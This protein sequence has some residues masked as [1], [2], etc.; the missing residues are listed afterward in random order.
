[1]VG[2][3]HIYVYDNASTDASWEILADYHNS[4]SVTAIPWDAPHQMAYITDHIK[5]QRLAYWHALSNYG[6][7]WRWMTFI[8]SDEFLMPAQGDNLHDLL[9]QYSDLPGLALFWKIFGTAG[10]LNPPSGLVIENYTQRA[11]FPELTHTKTIVDPRSVSV[12]NGVHLIGDQLYDEQR[13]PI[14]VADINENQRRK[15]SMLTQEYAPSSD[16][17]NLHHYYTRSQAEFSAKIQ[18]AEGKKA[19]FAES[20]KTIGRTLEANLASDLS[21]TRFV[22]QLKKRLEA[23]RPKH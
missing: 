18:R 1:M 11:P 2:V 13:R 23:A 16:V 3:E 20:M 19:K 14:R 9:Q 10:H 8:D 7:K 15:Q 4:G 22:P 12:V 21:A 6:P 5:A 17:F